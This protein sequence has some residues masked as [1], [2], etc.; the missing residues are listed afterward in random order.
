MRRLSFLLMAVLASVITSCSQPKNEPPSLTLVPLVS[1]V[2]CRDGYKLSEL[3][4]G[5][6]LTREVWGDVKVTLMAC[7]AAKTA[8]LLEV[9]NAPIGQTYSE[10]VSA[11]DCLDG[12]SNEF[13]SF[14]LVVHRVEDSRAFIGV[15]WG[16]ITH[17]DKTMR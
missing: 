9:H 10:W 6:S 17:E 16:E 3:K 1:E 7:D 12:K 8:C 5:E 13:G 14:G 2:T 11:G 15:P 4:V